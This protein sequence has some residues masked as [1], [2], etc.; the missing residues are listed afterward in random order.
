MAL[1]ASQMRG[2]YA[3]RLFGANVAAQG[4]PTQVMLTS[5]ALAAANRESLFA[6]RVANAGKWTNRLAK[7]GTVCAQLLDCKG[8]GRIYLLFKSS[9]LAWSR[10]AWYAL[11]SFISYARTRIPEMNLSVR[12]MRSTPAGST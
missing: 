8:Y 4:V 6:N 7:L 12:Y 1:F 9:G 3:V 10:F 2:Q 11:Q 5:D